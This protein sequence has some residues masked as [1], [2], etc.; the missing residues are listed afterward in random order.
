MG[1]HRE[2]EVKEAQAAMPSIT[3][4]R[5]SRHAERLTTNPCIGVARSDLRAAIHR[6]HKRQRWRQTQSQ[7][8]AWGVRENP[9]D[10]SNEL[11]S[12]SIVGRACKLALLDLL[13]ERRSRWTLGLLSLTCLCGT[14]CISGGS[15]AARKARGGDGG[16]AIHREVYDY[17][18]PYG[19]YA[20][21][22]FRR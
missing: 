15:G 12:R 14:S 18:T 13:M 9:Q 3:K 5:G 6:V 21:I 10:R 22:F 16:P 20:P 1:R 2:T 11:H 8:E 4:E 19:G 7:R 17:R